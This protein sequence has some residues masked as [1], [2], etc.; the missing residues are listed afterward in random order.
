MS[1]KRLK[2]AL[3]V[4]LTVAMMAGVPALA[5]FSAPPPITYAGEPGRLGD[6][7]SWRTPE[8]TATTAW[9]R[10]EPSSPTPPA[11]PAPG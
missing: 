4:A 10:S 6:P 2:T 1:T 5:Q 3:I 9:C 8:F 7:A 11:I